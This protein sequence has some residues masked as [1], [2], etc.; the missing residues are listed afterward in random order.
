MNLLLSSVLILWDSRCKFRVMAWWISKYAL[1][2]YIV[3][4]YWIFCM[5]EAQGCLRNTRV[6][7]NVFSHFF[8]GVPQPTPSR[9]GS[10][11]LVES[12]NWVTSLG[13]LEF[14]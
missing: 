5:W 9:R 8:S 1:R 3:K 7:Q 4:T 10:L 12:C 2:H 11:V 14:I 6:S 13:S